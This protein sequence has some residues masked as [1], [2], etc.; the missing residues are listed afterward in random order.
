MI[1]LVD[2][3]FRRSI[4]GRVKKAGYFNPNTMKNTMKKTIEE[5]AKSESEY[6]ADWE[7]KDMYI[8]GFIDGAKYQSEQMYSHEEVKKIAD[9]AYKMGQNGIYNGVFNKWFNQ[10][11][12]K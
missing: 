6:L 4:N 7:D 12:K 10:F 9:D 8:R 11:K 5:I 2:T 1:E 3:K